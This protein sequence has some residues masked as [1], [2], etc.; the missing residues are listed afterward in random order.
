[1][2]EKTVRQFQTTAQEAGPGISSQYAIWRMKVTATNVG[3]NANLFTC[4]RCNYAGTVVGTVSYTVFSTTSHVVGDCINVA[5]PGG[6]TGQ[7]KGSR[8][9]TLAEV[10]GA[11]IPAPTERYQV[12]TPI[13]DSLVPVWTDIRFSS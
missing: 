13:D 6:G 5:Q 9:V 3:G 2:N 7:T 4:V 10:I 1:M 8:D 12:Y 11:T